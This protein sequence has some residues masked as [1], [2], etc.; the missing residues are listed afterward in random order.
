MDYDNYVSQNFLITEN[1]KAK[2]FQNGQFTVH[3]KF[4][5]NLS[6]NMLL[7]MMV[8]RQ[9]ALNFDEWY[10]ISIHNLENKKADQQLERLE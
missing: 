5:N 4:A 8:S 10:N 3:I 6:D 7:V 9:K 1:L 2:K